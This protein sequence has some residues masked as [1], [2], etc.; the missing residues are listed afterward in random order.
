MEVLWFVKFN[1][2]TNVFR[3]A[4]SEQLRL[5]EGIQASCMG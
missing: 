3:K 5:L 4:S 2:H 1:V